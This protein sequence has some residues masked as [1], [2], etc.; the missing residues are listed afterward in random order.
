M[1]SKPTP[2]L[3]FPP[4]L[5]LF[6][7][8]PELHN[9]LAMGAGGWSDHCPVWVDV[10]FDNVSSDRCGPPL[11]A[12]FGHRWRAATT[13]LSGWRCSSL[14]AFHVQRLHPRPAP[15][16]SSALAA[17]SRSSCRSSSQE[18]PSSSTSSSSSSSRGMMRVRVNSSGQR[19]GQDG[20]HPQAEATPLAAQLQRRAASPAGHRALM[21][22]TCRAPAHRQQQNL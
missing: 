11:C 13:A 17:Q 1:L 10:P 20:C 2:P 12:C 5:H 19:G 22:L 15:A 16:S 7:D 21:H 9:I 6:F 3:I 4:P 8:R 18:S 14:R